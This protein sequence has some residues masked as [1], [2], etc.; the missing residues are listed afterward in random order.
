MAGETSGPGPSEQEIRMVALERKTGR[1]FQHQRHSTKAADATESQKGKDSQLD[2]KI[3]SL[4]EKIRLIQGLNSFGNTDFSSMSWFPNMTVPPK[5]KAPEFEKYNGRGDPM[6]H[7]QMYCRKMAPYADNE[8]LLIQTFQDT[9]TG[10][11][12][13]WYSQLKKISHWKELADTFLAQYG[14]N[15]QIAPDRFDLQKDGKEEQRD[16]QGICPKFFVDLIPVGD[17][18]E[19]ALKTKK[20]V[21]MTAL[22]ALAEQAAKKAPTK[23][24]EGDVQMIGRNNGRPRQV[25]P[26]FTMQPIQPRPIQARLRLK[27]RLRLQ[28]RHP[29]PQMP[30]RPEGNQPNDNSLIS[31]IVP[32]PYNGPQRR[33]FNPNS[34]CDFHFGE[35]GH[36]VENCGQLR[37]RVQDL[38]DHGVLKFEGLPNITTNPLPK[39]PEGGV[40]MVEVE[41]G[42]EESIAWRRLF[43]TLEKQKH[44]TPLDAP[45]G[46]ST[47][48]SCE[49]HSGA[50]G[51]SLDCCEEFK[52]KEIN[53]DDIV[54]DEMDLDNLQDEEADW[55]Y[56]M[57]DDTDEWRDVDFTE[58][59]QF[60]CLIVPP[61]F[62]TP[63][64]EIFYEDGDPEVHLQKYGE[65]MAL[66]L[67][68][69]LLMISVF[70]ES[71]SKQAA[72]WFY[73][74]RNLTG[75]DDLV[76][77]FL[78]RYRFNPHSILEYLGLKKDE[79]PYIIPDPGVSEG[80]RGDQRRIQDMSSLPALAEGEEEEKDKPLPPAIITTIAEEGE[81]PIKT[82]PPS[83]ITTTTAEEEYAGPMVE[84]LSIH[85]IT[86]EE[87]STTTPPTRHC[88]QGEEVKTWTCVP[89][90]QRVSS[91]NEIT[92]KTSNDPHVS[93]IDNKTDCSLDNIDNSDEEIEL[94]S[95]ILEALERQDEGSKP[96]IEELEIVNLANEGEE[97][98][99]VKIG[100]RCAA[101]QK[102][103]L[104][105][106]LREFHENLRLQ[107]LRRMKPEVILK[108]KEEVEKQLKAGFPKHSNL[109]GLGSQYSPGAEKGRKS[110]NQR[111]SYSHSWTDS[112]GTIRSRWP[113]EDKS[114]T[115][116]V[117]HWGTF[118]YDV[119]PFGLKNAGATYQRAMVTLFHDMIHH[120]IE[121]YVDDMI[122]KSRTAQDH[123]TDLR[124]LFQRLKKYQLRLNPNKCAFGV[125]SGKLLGFIVSGRGIEIDPAKLTATCEPLFK[126]LRKD[127]KIKWTED[128]QKAFDK[129]KEYLL[130]P[131]ILVPPTPGRPLILYLTVQEASM[132]CMLGQQDETGKKEQAIYYLSKKFTEPGDPLLVEF[133][134][135]DVMTVDE[136]NHGRWKL[137]FDGAANAVGSG[138]G[139]VLV[140][141]KGQ[142]T[143]IAV[144]LGFDCT[145]NMTE[146]EACIVVSQT[147]GEWQGPG[148]Q[149]HPVPTIHQ[150][151]SPKVQMLKKANRLIQEMHAGLMGAH[152]NGPFLARKIMR[153]GYYWLTMERDCI[154]HV[155]TCHKCQMYQNSKNAPPQYLHTMASPW[156]FSAWGMDVI[157]AITPKASNGHEFILVAIDYFTKWVEAC[158]FKNVT[159][160][161]VTRFVKNNIICRYG[162]P[163][164]LI[165]DNASNL[166]QPHDGPAYASSSRF[167]HHNSAPYRPKM[168]GAVEAANKNVK[169]IL[170]KMTGD[171][172]KIGTSTCLMLCALTELLPVEVEIPSLRI[173]SQT[174]LEE[175]E[176]A[177]ARYEQLNFID[178]KRLAALCH[179]QLYQRRIERAYNKKARPR[180]FQPGDL[181]LKKRNMALSDPRGKFAPSYEGPYVVKK[182]FSGGAIILADMD[183]EEFRSP[184][185]SDSVIKYH[186]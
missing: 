185:N 151:A 80:D 29:A 83:N 133:P 132:G 3:D 6:I 48:D 164:M 75:W 72:A 79:E 66:H 25:L 105:A 53:L 150:P 73:Q 175:A 22:M 184:I 5:F 158:S 152:A 169:K 40:N 117:T 90:L 146:Y 16:L 91:S 118:V 128:C 28:P 182:A 112:Q 54:E 74:L 60:P 127:V 7:L 113:K 167:Q 115:A 172:T 98:R 70:P 41:E 26:T 174:Q 104:I 44:I 136:D 144:K 149:A 131:P 157:G 129:I 59:F 173:L 15:S 62:V 49:Y 34:A 168:N 140:S 162:M 57:E 120:E 63:E 114:K 76:R 64:F 148:S 96:N 92:R 43:Y 106:L 160:V 55:G 81:E 108:I 154:R 9:L 142:Q 21:D 11:A 10:N 138:I 159:Q 32:K 8:P 101:E 95:D 139:A 13:E 19:D 143:P 126:L 176:W 130:N 65:K 88:Q 179:G 67:E 94:P 124:K 155:Q 100:T 33:D 45:P 170:S 30:A 102:E 111:T 50:R 68:N 99:E 4:E 18:I 178:E 82:P 119:M 86:E 52:K 186:V 51:H 141:P 153:A 156:P 87:D 77:V 103:A 183:G 23:R 97:P 61:G 56:F 12:A 24:K 181:V 180:T 2:S 17:R 134:D 78:E 27:L 39:H 47:G 161:A 121:V 31:P 89:L 58:F 71:L 37:H 165:T 177:Q 110:Q 166:K 123:L 163:E 147:N 137:Y 107:A 46:P 69:E 171:I 35:V 145:N 14:F 42:N 38:I 125:T 109:F 1:A 85:T 135:E 20:I 36:T 122:A 93:K 84:G 116:F